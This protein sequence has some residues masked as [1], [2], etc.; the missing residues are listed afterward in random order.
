MVPSPITA[1]PIN[2]YGYNINITEWPDTEFPT[3]NVLVYSTDTVDI[4]TDEIDISTDVE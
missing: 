1:T 4:T 2:D 3:S